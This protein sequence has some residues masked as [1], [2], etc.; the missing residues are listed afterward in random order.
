MY[1]DFSHTSIIGSLTIYRDMN[2]RNR[3]RTTE[4]PKK[5]YCPCAA[6]DC[7]FVQDTNRTAMSVETT[8]TG[9]V[10]YLYRRTPPCEHQENDEDQEQSQNQHNNEVEEH[11]TEPFSIPEDGQ[12]EKRLSDIMKQPV[13]E[14]SPNDEDVE[15]QYLRQSSPST[16]SPEA[17]GYGDFGPNSVSSQ[18]SFVQSR[19]CKFNLMFHHSTSITL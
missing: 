14:D 18:F 17:V 10:T 1:V 2:K 15:G 16:V 11:H 19:D 7:P 5:E 4:E 8:D 3:S 6:N 13:V 12:P 9:T